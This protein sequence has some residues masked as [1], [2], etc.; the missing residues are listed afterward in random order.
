MS[1]AVKKSERKKE[2]HNFNNYYQPWTSPPLLSE[3]YDLID[4]SYPLRENEED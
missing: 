3:Y 2:Y 4:L 1:S